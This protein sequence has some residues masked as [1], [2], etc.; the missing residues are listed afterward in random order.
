MRALLT[1]VRGEGTPRV[2]AL[3]PDRPTMI[4]RSRQCQIILRDERA[5]RRDDDPTP[6]CFSGFRQV[7]RECRG[8]DVEDYR[9]HRSV[10]GFAFRASPA[11]GTRGDTGPDIHDLLGM[12][13]AGGAGEGERVGWQ[14]A[15][16]DS[17]N[18]ADCLRESPPG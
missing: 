8:D 7:R 6:G 9:P 17:P 15:E 16:H 18:L 10:L 12:G 3:D 2:C 1:I 14:V 5:S 4:G 11:F 13:E